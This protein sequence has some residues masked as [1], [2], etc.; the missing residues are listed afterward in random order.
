WHHRWVLLNK[1]IPLEMKLSP[2][3]Q[4][5]I[6]TRSI[7]FSYYLLNTKKNGAEINAYLT[8]LGQTLP[9]ATQF[10][11]DNGEFHNF[12]RDQVKQSLEKK[13]WARASMILT[14]YVAIHRPRDG[15]TWSRY[16]GH[17]SRLVKVVEDAK[18]YELAFAYLDNIL[19][20]KTIP[21]EYKSKIVLLKSRISQNIPGLIPVA[22]NHPLYD[23]HMAAFNYAAGNESQAWEL[24]RKKIK[25]LP[26]NWQ[27]FDPGYVAWALDQM[28][29]QKMLKEALEFSF[30]IL[31]K[32]SSLEP[33]NAGRVSLIKGDIYK[34][35]ENF[36]AARLEYQSL[37]NNR[38]Y[39]KTAAGKETMFHLIDL[40]ILTKDYSS[41]E[42]K[43]ETLT[44][45]TDLGMQA[46]AYFYYARIS[47]DQ[48]DYPTTKDYLSEVF[49]RRHDHT[50]GRLLEGRLKLKLPR[51]LAGEI[52]VQVGD[53]RLRTVAIPGKTL[54]LKLQDA[55]LSIARGGA[56]IP[57]VITTSK[58]GDKEHIKLLP[59]STDRTLFSGNILTALG[60][61]QKGNLR[62]EV[63]GDDIISYMIDPEFQKAN[64][65][66]YPPKKLAVK[67]NANLMASAGKILT[68][69]EAEKKEME[70]R[71][72]ARMGK[73]LGSARFR[74]RTGKTVRPGS[75]IFVQVID[76]DGD[77]SDKPDTLSVHLKTE[78]G[79]VLSNFQLLETGAHTGI[80]RGAVPTKVPYPNVAVS[81]S[82]EGKDPNVMINLKR[83]ELWT[84][85]ADGKKPKWV[86]VDT[87]SSSEVTEIELI[88]PM[89]DKI[90]RVTLTGLLEDD[91]QSLANYPHLKSQKVRSTVITLLKG[92]SNLALA[93]I[94]RMVRVGN[95]QTFISKNPIFDRTKLDKKT[96]NYWYLAHVSSSFYLNEAQQLDL[97]FLSNFKHDWQYVYLFIDGEY[98]TGGNMKRQLKNWSR[99]MALGKGPHRLEFFI[100]DH[101]GKSKVELGYRTKE[102][103]YESLPKTWFDADENPALK[104][105]LLPKGV[106][107]KTKDG[108]KV[109]F[110]EPVRLRKIKFLFEDF[111]GN[112]ISIK[113]IRVKGIGG[114]QILPGNDDFST[115]KNNRMLEIAPGDKIDVTY[116]DRQRL[117]TDQE[118]LTQEL[119]STFFNGAISLV[120]EQILT[121]GKNRHYRYNAAKRCRQGDQLL[122]FVSDADFDLTDKRD[123]VNVTVKTSAGDKI[124]VKALE[125]DPSHYVQNQDNHSGVFLAILKFGNANGPDTIK[126]NPGDKISV[127]YLDSENTM[128]GI[129]IDRTYTL[130]EAGIGKAK[131]SIF[132][133]EINR[134][135]DKSDKAQAK[136]KRM[137]RKGIKNQNILI[138]KNEI[139]ASD[140]SGVE[141]YDSEKPVNISVNAPLLFQLEYAQ[142]ALHQGST[143][144]VLVY[145][146]SELK[147]AKRDGRK[148]DK[149]KVPVYINS[150]GKLAKINGYTIQ[151][152][153]SQTRLDETLLAEGIFSGLVRFQ[154]GS[155]GDSINDLVLAED[156]AFAT[157]KQRAKG[158]KGFRV[159]T[160]LVSGS[161]TVYIEVKD[162]KTGETVS[163]RALLMSN[164]RLE[165]LD[166]SFTYQRNKIHLGEKIYVQLTDPD[167]DTSDEQDH[168]S[169]NVKTANGD[170]LTLKLSETLKHSG[171]F[172]GN[173][174][175]LYAGENKEKLNPEDAVL[176]VVF[177]DKI[178][179]DFVDKL[180]L[181]SAD[182]L[183]IGQSAEIFHGSDADLSSFSKKFKDPEMAVKTRFLMAEALFE[184]AKDHRKLKNKA[185]AK[186]E[187]GE[188]KRILTEA[189]RDYPNT[190]LAGQ[191]EFLL[192]NLAS[193]LASELPKEKNE[194]RNRYYQEAIGRFSN[195]IASWPDSEYAPKAQFKKAIC[196]EKMGNPVQACEEYVKLTYI[197]PDSQLVSEATVRLG[198]YFY[199]TKKYKTAGRI[200]AKFQERKPNHKLA[201][202]ALFIAG[203][204][205]MKMED[206]KSSIKYMEKLLATYPEAHKI[207]PECMYWL[208]ES[209]NKKGDF[210]KAYQNFKKLTWDYPDGRW[211]KIARG[212]LTEEVFNKMDVDE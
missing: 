183:V 201:V 84:S 163:K 147:A 63:R 142:M 16:I 90:N 98:I 39:K 100:R 209:F 105:I 174:K 120:H 128:P 76:F 11:S 58:G 4:R 165:L 77:V 204:C 139:S 80:F 61:V 69:E 48:K 195:V 200:F 64:E 203:Q 176:Q 30:H 122:I 131:V 129:P 85:Q 56:A 3:S 91:Y 202:K 164:A 57:I 108:L 49:K 117:K 93:D 83:N 173:F 22:K 20:I 177:G 41:A 21:K 107:E 115:G 169:L 181:K 68:V 141:N 193:E 33:E 106:F 72:E 66:S 153:N 45:S 145:A 189:M 19:K 184:M 150:L 167:Q 73:T 178:T 35:M 99:R 124:T 42:G 97:K 140:P 156:K 5:W 146:E 175:P 40:M 161:D 88:T 6:P 78:S 134:V 51:S 29:K 170:K 89:I 47:F 179:L 199:G 125:T 138:Y 23:L 182:P 185:L 157:N 102:G 190:S 13:D 171:I 119:N 155:H 162:I 62:L 53:P 24:S 12:F 132:N 126:V 103:T 210:K 135:L 172:S 168:I 43:L 111:T 207:R 212:R 46:E 28:R 52:E 15:G 7:Q 74:G 160:L 25:A 79:D 27:T 130:F 144:N 31:L 67:S 96:K 166:K 194:Q 154:I 191:G 101:F 54:T 127:S 149:L 65:I 186:K 1:I 136:I 110:K 87:M 211:A 187:I 94:R 75:P 133:T 198:N 18:A 109:T 59:S 37:L 86:E 208:A 159:P 151:V 44:L 17:M 114:K 121:D 32:E 113:E 205:N 71:L 38:R 81:D 123:T 104:K 26:A 137:R 158:D 14:R 206:Y 82:E 118:I 148:T 196:L 70:E 152:K 8:K 50:Q 180:N 9:N 116:R 2:D 92:K 10:G 95:T 34:D 197:Y 188:G 143:F 192:A 55:N 112:A 60:K 36:Q